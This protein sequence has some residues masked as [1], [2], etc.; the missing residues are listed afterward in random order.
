MRNASSVLLALLVVL[1]VGGAFLLGKPAINASI[2][3]GDCKSA[4]TLLTSALQRGDKLEAAY[5]AQEIAL[6]CS[7]SSPT[8][9]ATSSAEPTPSAEPSAQPTPESPAANVEEF[10]A[11]RDPATKE[12]VNSYGPLHAVQPELNGKAMADLNAD[13][14]FSEHIYVLTMVD[15]MQTASAEVTLGLWQGDVNSRTAQFVEDRAV[16]DEAKI[17]VAERLGGMN[18]EIV[19]IPAWTPVE[20]TYS[21]PGVI[22]QIGWDTT[23]F[24]YDTPWLVYTD[25]ATGQKYQF[26]VNCHFQP[27]GSVYIP[28]MPAPAPGMDRTPEG[29]PVPV[30]PPPATTP[31]PAG[32]TTPPPPAEETTP[33]PTCPPGTHGEYPVCKD[34]PVNNPTPPPGGGGVAPEPDPE[35]SAPAVPSP[36]PTAEYTPPA[37][38][39]PVETPRENPVTDPEPGTPETTQ[40]APAVDPCAVDASLC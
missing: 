29:E 15:R 5:R 30:A 9:S 31:P 16:W 1:G 2:G 39:E 32:E 26:K 13:E 38:P 23:E 37:P 25:L 21:V 40:V 11:N 18:R 10:L 4:Q 35:P 24:S 14:A 6:L 12:T 27:G 20:V 36:E 7:G 17:Q 8:P 19:F 3:L 33:P 34:D 28:P 22:P